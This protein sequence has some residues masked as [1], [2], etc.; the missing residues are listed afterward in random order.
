MKKGHGTG[1]DTNA[2][3]SRVRAVIVK[4][5]LNITWRML[6]PTMFGLFAGMYI[7]TLLGS[8]PVGFLL[9]SAIG[10]L[11]GIMLALRVLKKAQELRV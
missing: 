8:S 7:D 2:S 1:P 3:R 5:L 11:A 10:F 6:V 4:D 9:G